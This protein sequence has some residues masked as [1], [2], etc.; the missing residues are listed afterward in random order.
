MDRFDLRNF[1]D[2]LKN[3]DTGGSMGM[4][5]YIG[6]RSCYEC[7]MLQCK[8]HDC[9]MLLE[10]ACGTL[11]A[12]LA[13]QCDKRMMTANTCSDIS[14]HSLQANEHRATSNLNFVQQVTALNNKARSWCVV[15]YNSRRNA[16]AGS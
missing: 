7:S 12:R 8:C 2:N 13:Y 3:G 14:I 5:L 9:C 6:K 1:L 4:L 16:D 15:L 10:I 11:L